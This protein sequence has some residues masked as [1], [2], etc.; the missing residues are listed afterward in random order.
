MSP[1]TPIDQD[2]AL[3]GFRT[4]VYDILG[5]ISRKDLEGYLHSNEGLY[6]RFDFHPPE[7][8][9]HPTIMKDGRI[10]GHIFCMRQ[11]QYF[12]NNASEEQQT[13]Y[14]NLMEI[15]A[16]VGTEYM[17]VVA[18]FFEPWREHFRNIEI[19]LMVMEQEEDEIEDDLSSPH[20]AILPMAHAIQRHYHGLFD[21][22]DF[23]V[24]T[25]G[26]IIEV[27]E[28]KLSEVHTTERNLKTD[29]RMAKVNYPFLF[30]P[31]S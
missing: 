8:L 2:D 4:R 27:L 18:N 25:S 3:A 20:Q 7:D 10:N 13:H 1:G 15:D 19:A 6:K 11:A 9:A 12:L 24:L 31:I 23:K 16:Q 22:I 14:Y 17:M 29:L 28:E 30:Y 5:D 21:E 26:E